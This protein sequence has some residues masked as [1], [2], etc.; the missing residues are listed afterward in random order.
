MNGGDHMTNKETS[1]IIL[2]L[3]EIGWT[4]TE[5]NDF[6]LFIETHNPTESEVKNSKTNNPSDT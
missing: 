5:I 4:D 2:R 1:N 3:R 6:I